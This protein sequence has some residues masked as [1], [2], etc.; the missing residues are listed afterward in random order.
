MKL[1]VSNN[2]KAKYIKL[3]DFAALCT[4]LVSSVVMAISSLIFFGQDFRGY[5]AA[6]RVLI[7]GGNPYD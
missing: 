5:F 4:W 1:V 2:M 6:A 7:I 3:G